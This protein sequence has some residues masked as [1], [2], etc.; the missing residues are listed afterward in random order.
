MLANTVN[1]VYLIHCLHWEDRLRYVI[2]SLR[3]FPHYSLR[4]EDS[5]Q[6][7]FQLRLLRR[8]HHF[9]TLSFN[10]LFAET[11]FVRFEGKIYR[12]SAPY[13]VCILACVCTVRRP[14]GVTSG[15]LLLDW[16][17]GDRQE[18][19]RECM[20]VQYR[21]RSRVHSSLCFQ[22]VSSGYVSPSSMY[23]MWSSEMDFAYLPRSSYTICYQVR[24][25]RSV[26]LE[27]LSLDSSTVIRSS[28]GLICAQC[29]FLYLACLDN[30]RKVTLF[31]LWISLRDV[32]YNLVS[33]LRSDG[34][35]TSWTRVVEQEEGEYLYWDWIEM[36]QHNVWGEGGVVMR[37]SRCSDLCPT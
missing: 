29:W 5:P 2:F 16:R 6:S 11:V 20:Y 30:P 36:L 13:L 7:F 17:R 34:S 12:H 23:F 14:L 15:F 37:S 27:F 8:S 10:P 9:P 22:I 4:L 1:E 32:P 28:A 31:S 26:F 25:L 19:H 18:K 33:A 3:A 35:S 21:Q 24:R